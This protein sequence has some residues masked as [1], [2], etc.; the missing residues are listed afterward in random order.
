MLQE[1]RDELVHSFVNL[2]EEGVISLRKGGVT[3][4]VFGF[5]PGAL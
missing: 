4:V 1:K 3:A 2:V 5:V